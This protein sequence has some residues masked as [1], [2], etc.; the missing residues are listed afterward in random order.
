M[1]KLL[2]LGAGTAGTI[3]AN[4][5][6]K[7]LPIKEWDITIIDKDETHFYQPGFL[8]IPFGIYKREDV[9]IPKKKF[10]PYGVT[11]IFKTVD[12]IIPENNEVVLIDSKIISY[13]I[14]IVATGSRI[15]PAETPGLK[16]NLWYK[17]I[18]DFYTIEGAEALAVFFKTWKG[19]KLVVNIADNP[20]KCPLAP[21]EFSFFADAF[22]TKKGIRDKVNITY[23][24]P[25]SGAFTKPRSSK[26]LGGL[27]QRKNIDLVPDFFLSE[28]DN[29]R[30]VIKEYG[31]REIPFDCLISIP[32]NTGDA[33]ISKSGLGDEY[34]FIR[35]NKNSLQSLQHKNIFVIGDAGNFPTSKA[36]SVAHY[37]AEVIYKNI[38]SLINNNQ[39]SAS[40]DGHTNCFLESGFGKAIL[41]DFNYDTEPLPGLFPF[42]VFGPFSL[43][44]ETRI[45][46]IG[47]LLFKWF[48]WNVLLRDR[49][50]VFKGNMSLKGKKIN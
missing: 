32:I 30:K 23:V 43:L 17:D 38:V 47:K 19:G 29:E 20:I 41:T 9:I 35:T 24:T 2:I 18:F 44:K 25:L 37:Q 15:N 5:L 42:P 13:D 6:R 33:T 50:S 11:L 4:K 12:R 28:V 27:L 22:F 36:G 39:L 1:K 31:S 21:L 34:G 3:V 10:I 26:L 7:K 45:N 49:I 46:H 14:L 16:G 8:Y 40:Y 48:Y